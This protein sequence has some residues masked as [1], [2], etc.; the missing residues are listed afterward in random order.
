M[1][2]VAMTDSPLVILPIVGYL[3]KIAVEHT[4]QQIAVGI[5]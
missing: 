5:E 2:T 1:L 3:G 4:A